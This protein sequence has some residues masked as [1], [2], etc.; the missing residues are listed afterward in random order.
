MAWYE[1]RESTRDIDSAIRID[2]ELK[3]AVARV[4]AKQGLAPRWL[5]DSAA[6]YA[7][8]TLRESDCDV[9]LETPQLLVLGAPPNV[10][11]AMKL[12]AN[13]AVDIPDLRRLW[14]HC[15]FASAAE[16]VN[17]FYTSYP[18]EDPDPHLEDF[19]QQHIINQGTVG[20]T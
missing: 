5:N 7:P 14:G 20:S 18:H 12:F 15:T 3:L 13:R 9:L 16:A 4:A 11:F 17:F 1:L 2:D 10:V 19:V 6:G 8:S